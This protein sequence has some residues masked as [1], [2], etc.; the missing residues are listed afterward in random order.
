MKHKT[1]YVLEQ[2]FHLNEK[3]ILIDEVKND[4]RDLN[5]EKDSTVNQKLEKIIHDHIHRLFD[6]IKN[7]QANVFHFI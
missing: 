1:Y 4:K 6:L 2:D 7:N 3:E 5:R